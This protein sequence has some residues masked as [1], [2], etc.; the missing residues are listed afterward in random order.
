M[1]IFCNNNNAASGVSK[2][3]I[4][5]FAVVAEFEHDSL[6]DCI[7]NN[8]MELAK[9]GRWLSGH[10]PIGFTVRREKTSN[11]KNESDYSYL[12]SISEEKVMIKSSMRYS[13]PMKV[14]TIF[15][16]SIT[17]VFAGMFPTLTVSTEFP[18]TIRPIRRNS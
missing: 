16:C 7:T 5:I 15:S 12:E 9:G 2:I 18:P 4:Q 11:S 13:P 8:I 17:E 10:T 14:H 1:W 3:F 6:T